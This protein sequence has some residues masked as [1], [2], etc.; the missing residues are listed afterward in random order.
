[1]KARFAL[2]ICVGTGAAGTSVDVWLQ[3]GQS[4]QTAEN[5]RPISNEFRIEF[6]VLDMSFPPAFLYIRTRTR[7]ISRVAV[8]P[9]PGHDELALPL[10]GRREKHW[11]FLRYT[12]LNVPDRPDGV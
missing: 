6:R 10:I 5:N 2:A 3:T 7:R 4:K 12:A 8:T 1:M 11:T 9:C